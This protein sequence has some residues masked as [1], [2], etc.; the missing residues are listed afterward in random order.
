MGTGCKA[1]TIKSVFNHLGALAHP[2]W[3]SPLALSDL[4]V[5]DHCAEASIFLNSNFGL[6]PSR[7]LQSQIFKGL[8]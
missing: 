1:I 8:A 6:A 7:P 3:I 4:G 5:T 2:S